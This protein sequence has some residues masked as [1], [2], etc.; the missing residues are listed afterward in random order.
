[1]CSHLS[2]L[3]GHYACVHFPVRIKIQRISATLDIRNESIQCSEGLLEIGHIGILAS[4]C[5]ESGSADLALI[6]NSADDLEN[7]LSCWIIG[8]GDG[9][10]TRDIQ[11]GKLAFYR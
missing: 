7:P 9:D 4:G 8:A 10:R 11:L 1:M 2:A 5:H 6:Q 3:A